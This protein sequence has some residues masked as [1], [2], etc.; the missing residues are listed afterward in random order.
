MTTWAEQNDRPG[1]HPRGLVHWQTYSKQGQLYNNQ[2]QTYS[3]QGQ[4]YNK[5]GGNQP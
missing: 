1:N 3:K 2:C 5:H 4:L